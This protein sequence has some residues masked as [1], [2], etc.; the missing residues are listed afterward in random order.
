MEK[1]LNKYQNI[2][3]KEMFKVQSQKGHNYLGTI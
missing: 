2:K 3:Q 1:E